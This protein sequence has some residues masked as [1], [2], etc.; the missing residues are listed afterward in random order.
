[1]SFDR[2]KRVVVSVVLGLAWAPVTQ[3]QP[4]VA[5]GGATP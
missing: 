2:R 5:P 4:A 1:M 3:A